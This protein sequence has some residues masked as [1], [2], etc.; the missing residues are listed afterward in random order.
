MQDSVF[1][2]IL[3]GVSV[4]VLG[5]F[6]LKL[7]LEPIVSFKESL[8]NLSAFC[9][10]YRAKITKAN[11]SLELQNEL[12]V[13]ISTIL[14]KSQSIPFYSAFAKVLGL[15]SQTSIIESCRILNG[16]S[17]EMVKE[18]SQHQGKL[19]GSIQILTDLQRVS[20]LLRVRLDYHEL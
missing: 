14:S 4:F 13:L 9:L 15:P 1:F 3:I 2:T 18:T 8:G 7:V 16:I 11:A 19:Q 12:K 5:Q 17:Y 10:R 20:E 6:I